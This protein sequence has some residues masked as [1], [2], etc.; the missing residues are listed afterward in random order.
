MYEHDGF[1][2]KT[3]G[4]TISRE[5]AGSWLLLFIL[6]CIYT[7]ISLEL[8]EGKVLPAFPF[9]FLIPA[10]IL[11]LR[12]VVRRSDLILLCQV[13]IILVAS[14]VFSK[15]VS[16]WPAKAV[17]V[18][19]MMVSVLGGLL[20]FR[21]TTSLSIK[22]VDR[23]LM[24]ICVALLLG[25]VLEVAGLLKDISD[26]FRG[27]A[28]NV[29][30]YRVYDNDLRDI[31]LT[32]NVRPKFFASEPSLLGIG[33]MVF[34]NGWFLLR[35]TNKRFWAVTVSSILAIM[36][37][38]SPVI[39]VSIIISVVGYANFAWHCGKR[40]RGLTKILYLA[41]GVFV[42]MCTIFVQ[43][44]VLAN[45][46]NA[47]RFGED[48]GANTS[49]NLRLF[50]PYQT[51]FLVLQSSPLF[52]TGISGKQVA[53]EI[54]NFPIPVEPVHL[55]GNNV[56]ALFIYLG[57]VGGLSLVYLLGK[58]MSSTGIKR[59][60]LFLFFAFCLGQ[61]LGGF[62]SPRFWAYLFLMMGILFHA[63]KELLCR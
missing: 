55:L 40:Q 41:G 6:F 32:D 51:A 45:R 36:V 1:K 52:G 33:F 29:G 54:A 22:S 12:K 39:F 30:G 26:C 35:P 58:Y 42:L 9:V 13:G 10:L 27:W 60:W 5:H 31:R 48:V 59:F 28:Y 63:D 7:E 46:F 62:E 4:M 38:S 3:Q 37:I 20:L 43:S 53:Y 14:V 21:L 49:E 19:Q 15:G 8:S 25:A 61:T 44:D 34:I 18:L 11:W 57:V 2:Q 23:V 50:L 16:Y 24:I 17:G 47:E 56:A